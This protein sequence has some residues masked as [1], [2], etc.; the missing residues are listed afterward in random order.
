MRD[1]KNTKAKPRRKTITRPLKWVL[2]IVVALIVLAFLLIPVFISSEICRKII[3]AKINTLLDGQTNFANLS[4][5]WFKGVRITDFSFND[6]LGQTFVQIKQ[7]ATKPHYSSILIGNLSFG[8]TLIDEP[9]VFINLKSQQAKKAIISQR[10]PSN[11][12]KTQPVALPIEKIDLEVRNGSLKVTDS[13]AQT[14]ELSQINSSLKLRPPGES[15]D[16]D[17]DLLVVDKDKASRISAEVEVKPGSK[18]GWTFRGTSGRLTVEVDDLDLGSLGPIFEL[19]KVELQA[20]GLVSANITGQLIDGRLENLS[21]SIKAKNLDITGAKLKGDRLQTNLLYVDVK[22]SHKKQTINIDRLQVRS[23]W[24]DAS[25]SGTIPTTFRSFADFLQPDLRHS[26]KGSFSCDLAALLSQMPRTFGLK[27]AMIVTSGKLTGNVDTFTKA[28]KATIAGQASLVGLAGTVDGKKLALSEPVIAEIKITGEKDKISFDKLDV[29]AAFAKINATGGM[30]RIKYDSQVDLSKFQSELGQFIDI[31]PYQM[32][33]QLESRGQVSIKQDKITAIGSSQVKNLTLSSTEGVT[34]SEPTAEAAFSFDIDWKNNIV[35]ID[36]IEANASLG[37]VTMKDAVVPF[38]KK[39]TKP[40]NLVASAQKIDLEKLQPFMVLFASFPPKMQLAGTAES[41]IHVTSGKDT[42][43]ITTDSTRIENFKIVSAGK[44][45]FQQ[46]EVTLVFDIEF[47]PKQ[48]AINVKKLELESPQ[49]KIKKGEFKK[50][51]EAGKT[52][53]QGHA[54]LEYDWSAVSAIVSTFLPQGLKL[55]GQRQG[56]INFFCEYPIGQTDK[57]LANLNTKAK[58]GFEKAQYLGLN[59]GS[60][61]VDIQIQNGL[62]N[63][64]PFST[65]VNNGQFK[66]AGRADF[67]QKPAILRTPGP[68]EI[69]KDIQINKET[70]ERLLTYVNPIFANAVNVSGVASFHCERLAIPLASADKSDIE[71]IGTISINKLHL[72]ASDLLGQ[73][74]SVADT[75]LRGQEI[76]I[77]PTRFVLQKGFLRYDNMQMDVGDNPVNFKGVIGL[78][79]SLNMTVILPYTTRGRTA[80]IG[81]ENAGERIS[82][83]IKG[84]IDK[85][86]LDVG[87]LLQQQLK[88]QL[89]RGLEEL[90]R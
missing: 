78:D 15:T 22:L 66:F 12:G 63:I 80:R 18:K 49:I 89:R 55:A 47:N 60:T 88:E 6:S 87:K 85:P 44:E 61:E 50:A 42:Y 29:S 46:A 2:A 35:T 13:K 5:G 1:E 4:M 7:I 62:L 83:P 54:N 90:F 65:S 48:K 84:T 28:K 74:L 30:E 59:F 70:T 20:K 77:H 21:A 38:N 11:N 25:V 26:L 27:E 43:R 41:Q 17:V 45:P 40:M 57:L 73:I 58:L 79:K 14:V 86:E 32:A 53:L 76:T 67:K 71:I 23:D 64:A 39:A 69:A 9:T 31:G 72:Q 24:T 33:G 34:A 19:A 10:E 3:L 8:Q 36:S 56:T 82:L 75:S 51:D 68:I 37:Q 52:K 16:F 81:K